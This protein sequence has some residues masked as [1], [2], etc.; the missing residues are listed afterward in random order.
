M[1]PF[2]RTDGQIRE[3]NLGKKK[4][5]NIPSFTQKFC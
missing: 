1:L 5:W 4:F 3:K 2:I